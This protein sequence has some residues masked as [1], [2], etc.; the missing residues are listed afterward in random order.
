M[1][2]RFW[3]ARWIGHRAIRLGFFFS[4]VLLI[5]PLIHLIIMLWGD[6]FSARLLAQRVA[7]IPLERVQIDGLSQADA[8]HSDLAFLQDHTRYGFDR[9]RG[10]VGYEVELE[11]QTFGGLPADVIDTSLWHGVR[12][13]ALADDLDGIERLIFDWIELRKK[14]LNQRF[15]AVLAL[16]GFE[17]PFNQRNLDSFAEILDQ[18]YLSPIRGETQFGVQ[19]DEVRRIQSAA[20]LIRALDIDVGAVP[21]S[22]R[23]IIIADLWIAVTQESDIWPSHQRSWLRAFLRANGNFKGVS[24]NEYPELIP[25]CASKIFDAVEGFEREFSRMELDNAMAVIM[26]ARDLCDE[27]PL[28]KDWMTML[29]I[30]T[31]NRQLW[32]ID[33]AIFSDCTDV[34]VPV[35]NNPYPTLRSQHLDDLLECDRLDALLENPVGIGEWDD[36]IASYTMATATNLQ[37]DYN[38]LVRKLEIY[39]DLGLIQ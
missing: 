26:A 7:P 34:P 19:A 5:F 13:M 4:L 27:I 24:W 6:L 32:R 18:V 36:R 30:Q 11:G 20:R 8:F 12:L 22:F 29:A 33:Q 38:Y 39:E 21:N 2:N 35:V 23:Q 9:H 16:E 14:S 28:V 37:N 10:Y 15:D 3:I 1:W 17:G 31:L 25:L